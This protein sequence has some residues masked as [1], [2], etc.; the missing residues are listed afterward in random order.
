MSNL[1]P[2]TT[3][4]SKPN[5]PIL[6]LVPLLLFTCFVVWVKLGFEYYNLLYPI[7]SIAV[8]AV[9]LKSYRI[10]MV[11]KIVF[12]F[13]LAVN[14]LCLTIPDRSVYKLRNGNHYYWS[15][16]SLDLS[17]FKIKKNIEN[18]IAATVNPILIGGINKVYN[19]PPAI[20]FTSYNK[21][22]SWLDT[23]RFPDTEEGKKALLRLL[24]HEK[25]H[26]DITEIYLRKAL[27][28]LYNKPLLSYDEKYDVVDYFFKT[29]NKIQDV[30]DRE[31]DLGTIREKNIEWNDFI[32]KALKK[33]GE[34]LPTSKP[35]DQ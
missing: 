31:T 18:D 28:S 6:A 14:F 4:L 5:A 34:L 25:N 15:Q 3:Q 30:F 21:D 7:V 19:Y 13:T 33:P 16:E 20:L 2:D 10:S 29:S 23:S 12:L 26:L 17:H 8:I 24:Q 11:Y 35:N 9:I 22:S 27:D 32:N 1:N